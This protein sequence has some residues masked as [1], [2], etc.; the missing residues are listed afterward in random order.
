MWPS[1]PQLVMLSRHWEHAVVFCAKRWEAGKVCQDGGTQWSQMARR[2]RRGAPR[3][4]LCE[5][6]RVK[7][8]WSCR[9]L[10]LLSL[11]H[12]SGQS[13]RKVS[14][15]LP[16]LTQYHLVLL[17]L[18]GTRSWSNTQPPSYHWYSLCARHACCE[19]A[20]SEEKQGLAI[21]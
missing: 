5:L 3:I 8:V 12:C 11:P 14:L 15:S 2:E 4:T 21:L 20:G 19:G 17:W 13:G 6:R 10:E 18:L 1:K 16:F 9:T 7:G